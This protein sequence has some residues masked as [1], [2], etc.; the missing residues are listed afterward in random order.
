MSPYKRFYGKTPRYQKNL[1]SFGDIGILKTGDKIAGK[2]TN[3]GDA[4]MMLGYA[5]ESV[6][7]TYRLLRLGTKRVVKSR[8]VRQLHKTYGEYTKESNVHNDHDNKSFDYNDLDDE[9]HPNQEAGDLVG[10]E[11]SEQEG[12]SRENDILTGTQIR[13][14]QNCVHFSDP[15]NATDLKVAREL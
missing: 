2:L 9:D 3:K 12:Q 13:P 8:N 10:E 15:I 7:G 4:Y 6:E 1:R 11:I 5:T 14:T